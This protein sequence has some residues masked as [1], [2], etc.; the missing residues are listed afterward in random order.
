GKRKQ[1]EQDVGSKATRIGDVAGLSDGIAMHLRQ[2]VDKRA[3]V[4]ALAVAKVLT[5]VDD[6]DRIL[7]RILLQE[8]AAFSVTQAEEYDVGAAQ[9]ICEYY[10]SLSQQVLVYCVKRFTCVAPAVNKSDLDIGMVEEEAQRFATGVS[11]SAYNAYPEFFSHRVLV[12]VLTPEHTVPGGMLI[13]LPCRF[14]ISSR[15]RIP[16]IPGK[17]RTQARGPYRVSPNIAAYSFVPTVPGTHAVRPYRVSPNIVACSFIPTVPRDA[18]RASLQGESKYRCVF[19]CSHSTPGR[20]PCVP[21][22]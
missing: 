12:L 3:L 10:I 13:F 6:L 1:A 2:S 11:R 15:I 17:S 22:G 19:I 14:H 16:F 9:S 20:T 21:T 7:K 18:R 4:G 8:L 5:K